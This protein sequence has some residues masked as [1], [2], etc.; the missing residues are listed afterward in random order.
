MLERSPQIQSELPSLF[1]QRSLTCRHLTQS[2]LRPGRRRAVQTLALAGFGALLNR[3]AKDV[4][5]RPRIQPHPVAPTL[6]VPTHIVRPEYV[7]SRGISPENAGPQIHTGKGLMKMRQACQLAAQVLQHAGTLV[8]EGVTTD[9]IDQEVH[10]MIVENGAYPSPLMYGA[11]PKS[12]CTSVNEV[13]CHGIPDARE[14]QKGDIINVDVTVYLN[15]YHGDTSA[16]FQVGE[17]SAEAR[18]LCEVTQLAM[19]QGIAECRPG[20]RIAVI[21]RA[22]EAT[23]KQ[24]KLNVIPDFVGHGVGRIFHSQ[25]FVFPCYNNSHDIMQVGQ[26]FTVEPILVTGRPKNRV[27]KD[28]WTAVTVDGGLAAQWEHTVLITSSG[29]EVLTHAPKA[30]SGNGKGF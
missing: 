27:W 11:F 18:R 4:D 10:K 20:A 23:A 5:G 17:V 30:S 21:G 3:P 14:L 28:A 6:E 8:Q 12:V 22:I 1:R 13:C 25:P 26:T 19:E 15:G 29:H 2:L 7:A 9:F 24:H 16:M